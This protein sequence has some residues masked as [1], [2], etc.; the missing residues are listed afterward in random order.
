MLLFHWWFRTKYA[1]KKHNDSTCG[2]RICSLV[3]ANHNTI[4]I[5]MT[6][7][8]KL[9]WNILCEGWGSGWNR[10]PTDRENQGKIKI[11]FQVWKIREFEK[12]YKISG[13]IREFE[14]KLQNFRE[15]QG[16]WKKSYKISGKIR[17]FD[18]R[19]NNSGK[20]RKFYFPMVF[21]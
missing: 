15:N 11:K 2:A 14:K 17:E 1:V 13:K 10:V 21:L 19:F 8:W 4:K 20:I 7:R 5:I 16:I 18:K 12:S 6:C 3:N 9:H